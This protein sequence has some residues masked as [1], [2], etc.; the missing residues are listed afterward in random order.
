MEAVLVV[1]LA[2]V[3]LLLVGVTFAAY[4]FYRKAVVYDE[5]F[6][7]ISGDL[8]V[9][10]QQFVKMERSSVTGND[11]EIQKAHKNMMVMGKRFDEISRR[12]EEATGLALRP[13]PAPPKPKVI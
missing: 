4:R 9:N 8:E 5:I 2:V 6:Q 3:T 10:M 11:P 1:C 12:M 7:F 13:P